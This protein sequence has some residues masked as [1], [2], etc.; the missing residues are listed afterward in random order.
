[1][2]WTRITLIV[3]NSL[4]YE[5]SNVS[6]SWA[7]TFVASLGS[8]TTNT[9]RLYWNVTLARPIVRDVPGGSHLPSKI[10]M[11]PGELA[12]ITVNCVTLAQTPRVQNVDEITLQS[13]CDKLFSLLAAGQVEARS[14]PFVFPSFHGLSSALWM[15][16]RIGLGGNSQNLTEALAHMHILVNNYTNCSIDPATQLAQ[17][18]R[19]DEHDGSFFAAFEVPVPAVAWSRMSSETQVTLAIWSDLPDNLTVSTVFLVAGIPRKV[20]A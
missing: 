8:F 12:V 13:D 4:P 3:H 18:V 6:L 9:R 1:M 5:S 16:V 7:A 15:K 19:V 10:T 2:G 20:R 11:G 17:P 14:Q